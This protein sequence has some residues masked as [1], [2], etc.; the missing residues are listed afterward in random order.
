VRIYSAPFH[1]SKRVHVDVNVAAEP[2]TE[3]IL[4]YEE[5]EIERDRERERERGG[6]STAETEGDGE[7]R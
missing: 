2:S 1:F 4:K 7:P 5:R 6:G 3:V